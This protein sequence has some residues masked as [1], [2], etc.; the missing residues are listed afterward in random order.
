MRKGQPLP[1]LWMMSDERMGDAFLPAL[2]RL[3]KGAGLVFRHYATPMP[4]RRALFEQARRICRARRIL[5]VLA[6]SP[7]TAAGWRADGVHGRD[8]VR[9]SRPLVRTAPVHGLT[10]NCAATKACA[11]LLFVSPV[12]PTQSHPSGRTL[13]DA[14]LLALCQA[15]RAP[16][17]ALGGMTPRQFKPLKSQGIYGFAAIDFWIRPGGRT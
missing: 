13:G 3:P 4:E 9:V 11:D 15:S 17:I 7:R 5:L 10:E 16:V 12:H 6:A 2:A 8:Q 14:G 1:T